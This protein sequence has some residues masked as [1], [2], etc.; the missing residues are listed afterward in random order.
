LLNKV[1]TVFKKIKMINCVN[2]IYL[3]ILNIIFYHPLLKKAKKSVLSCCE[4]NFLYNLFIICKVTQHDFSTNQHTQYKF[5]KKGIFGAQKLCRTKKVLTNN[6]HF[7][8]V[9]EIFFFSALKHEFF[10]VFK[11][12]LSFLVFD[13]NK[14]L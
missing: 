3:F 4:Q 5:A 7:Q 9:A 11:Q 13:L 2:I 12:G 14:K 8:L 10:G 1:E 6:T